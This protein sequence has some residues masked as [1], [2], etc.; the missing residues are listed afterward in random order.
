MS[1]MPGRVAQ[2]RDGM[3]G[4]NPAKPNVTEDCALCKGPFVKKN[5]GVARPSPGPNLA[6]GWQRC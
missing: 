6:K 4:R 2:I 3:K 5:C 1:V